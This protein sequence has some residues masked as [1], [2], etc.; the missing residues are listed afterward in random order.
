MSGVLCVTDAQHGSR[1]LHVA[2]FERAAARSEPLTFLHVV[3]GPD[4]SAHG[5]QMRAAILHESEWLLHAMLRLARSRA[6]TPQVEP[7]VRVRE[8]EATSEILAQLREHEYSLLVV[9]QPRGVASSHFDDAT[10][11]RL[12]LDVEQ[13]AVPVETVA[14]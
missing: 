12:L 5:E 14:S 7:E 11:A 4:Y 9:G 2:A 3:G 6:G 13:L 10:F 8:G 1:L